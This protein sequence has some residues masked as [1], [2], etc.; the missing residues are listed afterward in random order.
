[1]TIDSASVLKQLGAGT[2]IAD[3]CLATG[4]SRD[5]FETWWNAEC[6]ARVPQMTGTRRVGVRQPVTVFRDKW[7]VPHIHADSDPDLFFGYG[8]AMAQDRLFQMDYQRR[9]GAGRS[10]EI[11]GPRA[12]EQDRLARIVGLRQIAETELQR[13]P[14][15]T[16]GLLA[17]F[18]AGVNALIEGSDA[19]PIEFDLLDYRPEPW[20]ALDC[21]VIEGAFRWYLTGRLPILAIPELVKRALAGTGLYE[22]LLELE[23]PVDDESI[24]DS[25]VFGSASHGPGLGS[26]ASGP[27]QGQ[28]S[29]NWT[30][31][32]ARSRHGRPVFATDPHIAFGSVSCWYE[33]R[34]RG[35]SFDVAG[36]GYV[37]VPGV[38]F[39][40]NRDVAWGVTNNLCSQRD[41]F[42][43]TS[44]PDRPGRFQYDGG[45]DTAT[46]IDEQIKV[47]GSEPVAITVKSTRNGPIVDDL[48]PDAAVR[49]SVSLRWLGSEYCE[50]LSSLL[51][52]NRVT[53]EEE[54]GPAIQGWLVPTFNLLV[55]DREGHIGYHA[56]GRIP[57]RK[58]SERGYRPGWDPHYQWDGLIPAEAMPAWVDPDRGWLA[59][60]NNRTAG[61]DYPFDLGGV[62]DQPYRAR[63]I[64]HLLEASSDVTIED[65]ASIQRDALSL[66]A[67]ECLPSLLAELE[68]RSLSGHHAFG[69]ASL[70]DWDG[71]LEIDSVA[72]VV[73]EVFFR[74]WTATV[75]SERIGP[76]AHALVVD[77]FSAFATRFLV[78]D[79]IG[80]FVKGSRADAIGDSYDAAIEELRVRLGDD[81]AEWTWGR[82]H[83]LRLRH[84]LADGDLG[85]LLDR[86]DI[87]VPGDS[88]TILNTGMGRDWE[89]TFGPNYRMIA[90]LASSPAEYYAVDAQ[91]QSGHPGSSHYGDQLAEWIAG[92]YRRL[93][94][95]T[96]D[97]DLEARLDLVPA[98]V[99]SPGPQ[100]DAR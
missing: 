45:W 1:M 25:G 18:A 51:R 15:E 100:E 4:I 32:S 27:D 91:G 96:T 58:I 2:S 88:T 21:L 64:R 59:S 84:V 67:V 23:H 52:L 11:L 71:R 89:V 99:G 92:R 49:G 55:A 28:G 63:R 26:T 81:V 87:A 66:R 94:F 33:V 39:G 82:L 20:S 34:L 6:E 14:D 43:E 35:G 65:M 73:F 69:L 7:G 47:R 5:R 48:L 10:A 97:M 68:R 57:R 54:V 77:W 38:L 36:A 29:N 8:Y 17:S 31:S 62:W 60:A 24:V 46:S 86:H 16:R 3:V 44:D 12:V 85:V 78:S 76:E 53:S 61:S 72:A 9:L 41:L 75:A 56:T 79:S 42:S 50:W 83:R 98:D 70:R 74:R 19:R 22:A 90:D 80:W 13:L 93:S 95:E 30:V 40:R 37:G